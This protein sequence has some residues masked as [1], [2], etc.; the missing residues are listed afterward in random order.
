MLYES[1]FVI[2]GQVTPKSAD[3]KFKEFQEFIK[4]SGGKI[5]KS[6]SWGLRTLA[7]K[8]K[9][10]TKGYYFMINTDCEVSAFDE[11]KIKLKQDIN[12]LR[13]LNLKIKE[14]EKGNSF[15]LENKEE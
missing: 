9:K 10:N 5:L 2:S 6:E 4:N 12:F 8:I 13:F 14:V 1:V 7:Y 15:L 11:L 3:E